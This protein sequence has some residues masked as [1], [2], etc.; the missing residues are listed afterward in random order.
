MKSHVKKHRATLL[1]SCPDQIGIVAAVASFI[2]ERSGNIIHSDQHT[3]PDSGVFYMR[4]EW[5][6]ADATSA[7][8]EVQQAFSPLAE[9]F[10]MQ[11]E[12]RFAHERKRVAIMVSKQDHC[13]WDLLL[14]HKS[15]E[16]R[17]DVPVVL[18][19]H[20]N[21]GPVAEAFGIPYRHI[22]V[23]A[24][25]KPQAEEHIQAAL[26]ELR[27]D[28]VVLA[29][30]MQILSS[31]FVQR[32]PNR[33]INIHHSFLPAFTGARPYHQAYE[34]GVKIIGATS[35]YVTADLDEGP[36][37]RQDVAQVSHRHTVGDMIRT[38]RDLEKVVLAHALRLHLADRVLV[39][40]RKTVVFD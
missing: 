14:R 34:R 4:V 18:S 9:R 16:L 19:N 30:Y 6:M 40:G 29:R 33:I 12:L 24:E 37:I 15:G 2:Q 31:E 22:P 8:C 17:M 28:L 21:L 35:H 13:L 3:D 10:D 39:Y 23:S 1:I 26:S 36:I 32:W 11:F 27:V 25:T 5:E 7:F 20:P 38:G